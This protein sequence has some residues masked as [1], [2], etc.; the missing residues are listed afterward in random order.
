[1]RPWFVG[2]ASIGLLLDAATKPAA[3]RWLTPRAPVNVVGE[4]V[5]LRLTRNTVMAF[6][7]DIPGAGAVV[8]GALSLAL[9]GAIVVIVRR[10]PPDRAGYLVA[11]G[12]IVAGG[13][14]NLL[15]RAIAAA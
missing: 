11:F 14:G 7:L 13:M 8:Y 1:M 12:A 10:I 5:R 4:V 3:E 2:A 15:T 9:I 6:G